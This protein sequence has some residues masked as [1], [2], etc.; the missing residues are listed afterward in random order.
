MKIDESDAEFP[1]LAEIETEGRRRTVRSK[2]L[3]GADGAH[4]MVRRCMG[5][6][7]EG[8]SLDHIW[9]VVDLIVDTDFPD[10][11][12]RCAIHSPAGSVMVIPRE[13]IATGDYLTRL[14]VQV[15]G[16]VDP[17][18]EQN[19]NGTS[20]PAPDARTRRSKV[21]EETIF[22]R[23]AA[24]FKPYYIRPK[25]DGAVDWWAA[26]QI[27]QRVT[28]S[29]SVKDSKGM[30]RV[31]IAGDGTYAQIL[32]I[33]TIADRLNIIACHT[34]SP[35]AG[36][37]MNVSMMDSYNLAWKLAYTIHGLTPSTT[38]QDPLLDTYHTERHTI[39]H[40][41]IDFDRAFSSM[42]SGKIGASEDGVSALTHEEFMQVFSRGNGF[43]SG[44]GV[45]YPENMTV[46]RDLSDE[47]NPVSGTDY[48]SGVLRPGRR[49]LNVR[50]VRHADG[51]HRDLQDGELMAHTSKLCFWLLT[52]IDFLSTGRFRILCLASDDLLDQKG[53]SAKTLTALGSVIA[54][55][56][57]SVL[58]QV[59]VHPRVKREFMWSDIPAEVKRFSE[60]SFYS[61]YE[62]DDVYGTYGV[63]PA[64]GA[65]AVVRPDGYV[66]AVAELGD[67]ERVEAYLKTLVGTV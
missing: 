26:Y 13:R 5:L 23:A 48:L 41:L 25:T 24:A 18:N 40:Q 57:A 67:V 56:P 8:E 60:M 2:Y 37:G 32:T 65:I 58:E 43:T 22:E 52:C 28:D 30:N 31:F 59:V 9:G 35:K 1:V 16:D 34:H 29:F 55:F 17:E 38:N 49:L 27:G 47:I 20:T 12:R 51:Y 66:G 42:F 21:T 63:D 33:E 64:R 14:Y 45:E 54:K 3:V 44:C 15:P 11:R 4:S 10:I 61:G 53:V 6:K 36:Q 50:L 62:L 46:K 7:L 39:A 19:E